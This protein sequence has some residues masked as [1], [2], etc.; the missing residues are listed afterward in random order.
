[1]IQKQNAVRQ[2]PVQ[3]IAACLC[4]C[5]L[6]SDLVL[7]MAAGEL[8]GT[9]ASMQRLICYALFG[10]VLLCLPGT[11]RKAAFYLPV[12]YFFWLVA[13][14]LLM[15]CLIVRTHGEVYCAAAMCCA[16]YVPQL[17]DERWRKRLFN[18]FCGILF[19]LL[20][21]WSIPGMLVVTNVV[22][23]VPFGD[24]AIRIAEEAQD[25]GVLRSLS[26]FSVHRNTSAAW[27]MVALFLAM[28]Q[29]LTT[30]RKW[31]KCLLGAFAV[32]MY[33]A[34]AMQHCRSVCVAA[35]VG[36]G[37]LSILP[38][39]DR[40]PF[41]RRAVR[42][43][44]VGIAAAAVMLLAYKGFGLCNAV[45]DCIALPPAVSQSSPEPAGE[46]PEAPRQPAEA[47][48]ES[49]VQQEAPAEQPAVPEIPAG[50]PA[51]PETGV[52]DNRNFLRDLMTLTMRTEIW[53]ASIRTT[54]KSPASLFLGQPEGEIVENL[55]KFGGLSREVA[56]T[57]NT[58]LQ[59]L[60]LSG[61]VGLG[62]MAAF[63][64]LQL[65]SAVRIFLGNQQPAGKILAVLLACL[66]LY[67]MLEPLFS[68]DTLFSS[69]CFMLTA[70]ILGR[71]GSAAA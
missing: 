4:V 43:A 50:Q 22:A 29:L 19:V 63:V 25:T 35:S 38:V 9:F 10:I 53:A 15:D 2:Q 26:F 41:R 20:A 6:M 28:V 69:V 14:R 27:L 11:R 23:Q 57:H 31:L 16:F 24:E 32:L 64:C 70:G 65:F 36:L 52:S 33:A 17:L 7:P 49:P 54:L 12:V 66:L 13:S 67:G 40:I 37:L 58:F 34:I 60:S 18:W 8:K 46:L 71:D 42:A 68:Y 5:V 62:I 61:L 45:V 56:H 59:L 21:F 30:P 55:Q 3:I 51:A 48:P 44:C 1:M 47:V 39:K